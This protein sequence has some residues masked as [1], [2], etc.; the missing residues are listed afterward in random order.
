MQDWNAPLGWGYAVVAA[1]NATMVLLAL[2]ASSVLGVVLPGRKIQ[3]GPRPTAS[4][5]Y[6]L[7]FAAMTVAISGLIG[8][9]TVQLV[10]HG[11]IALRLERPSPAVFLAELAA[12]FVAFDLWFYLTHR[13]LHVAPLYR[14]VHVIHHRSTVPNPLS[15]FSAHPVETLLTGCFSPLFWMVVPIHLA[16]LAVIT[17]YYG[18]ITIVFHSGYDLLPRWWHERWFS[19]WTITPR[20]HDL[21]HAR[22]RWNYG[23][24][25][26]LWDALFGT[27]APE[28]R[29]RPAL[30]RARAGWAAVAVLAC[31]VASTARAAEPDDFAWK[32]ALARYAADPLR[33]RRA[34]R[35][36]ERQDPSALPPVVL[37]AIGD[38]HLRFRHLTRAR[39]RFDQVVATGVGEPFQSWAEL[40]LGGVAMGRND[41]ALARSH[42]LK[43]AAAGGPS[44]ALATVLAALIDTRE[45][46]LD[47][48]AA[49]LTRV[50]DDAAAHP[51]VRDV[52]RLGSAYARFWAGRWDDAAE[53][54]MNASG[55]VSDVLKD[56]ARYGAARARWRAGDRERAVAEM[57]LLAAN[58]PTAPAKSVPDRLI[59]LER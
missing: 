23:G 21:H 59:A 26:I 24:Y 45:N 52:A 18:A 39:Q 51:M 55:S 3:R 43:V 40:G 10:R 29:A 20:Y 8:A 9:A 31:L 33:N 38:S 22:G 58:D 50:A 53:A 13:L 2:V 25:T 42:Y 15:A 37:L 14:R 4:R 46:Y 12:Y 56:D 54:F 49:T 41:H 19:R 32:H 5:W 17:I 34:L 48:A 16:T 35:L 57:R 11:W 7:G 30:L 36:L 27:I 6:E 47:D 44:A 28:F 1:P